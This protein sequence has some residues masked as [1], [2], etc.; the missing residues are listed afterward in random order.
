MTPARRRTKLRGELNCGV[1]R[2]VFGSRDFVFA[3]TGRRDVTLA[4]TRLLDRFLQQTP[5]SARLAERARAV[6]P[7]GIADYWRG[8]DRIRSSSIMRPAAA[9]GMSM[10]TSMSTTPAAMVALLA[11]QS[12]R[13]ETCAVAEA[14]TERIWQ[15]PRSRRL[16]WA[17]LVQQLVPSAERVRSPVRER[18]RRCWPC[19]WPG[20]SPGASKIVRLAGHFHGWHDHMAFG[21]TSHFDGTPRPACCPLS[22]PKSGSGLGRSREPGRRLTARRRCR[23]DCR[24]D[25]CELGSGSRCGPSSSRASRADRRAGI[26]LIFDEVISGFR[27]SPGGGGLLRHHARYH[28]AGQDPGRRS[29]WRRSPW[30]PPPLLDQLDAAAC[31]RAGREKVPHQGTFNANPLSRRRAL[32]R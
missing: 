6:L 7:G 14:N 27:C 16:Q 1:R 8:Q 23:R 19:G 25:R 22:R 31:Q 10:V 17:E 12:C 3:A 28:D 13:V 29:A 4:A 32:P 20:P 11:E 24:T 15:L 21:V 5:R 30:A 26:V 9:S 2:A 18:R